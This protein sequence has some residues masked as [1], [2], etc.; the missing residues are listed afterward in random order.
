MRS[1]NYLW[2]TFGRI[3]DFEQKPLQNRGSS[4]SATTSLAP[5]FLILQIPNR[6]RPLN[7]H[8]L[9]AS[10]R[11]CWIFTANPRY[12]NPGRKLRF[13]RG[14]WK[15]RNVKMHKIAQ[16]LSYGS[17]SAP[18]P[19]CAPATVGHCGTLGRCGTVQRAAGLRD[20]GASRPC[21]IGAVGLRGYGA[22][23]LRGC[24]A[25]ECGIMGSRCTETGRGRPGAASEACGRVVVGCRRGR[26]LGASTAPWDCWTAGLWDY[27]TAGLWDCG[28]APSARSWIRRRGAVQ[29]GAPR[30]G[31]GAGLGRLIRR[32]PRAGQRRR[33]ARQPKAVTM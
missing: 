18:K 1:E 10:K 4:D 30:R 31:R 25:S 9:A 12:G 32:T 3:D 11:Y 13:L 19:L 29:K 33:G 15:T 24:G 28:T 6:F 23:G 8:I 20:C 16:I 14:G 2:L 26:I 7:S 17:P 21:D 27:G 5:K 22:M